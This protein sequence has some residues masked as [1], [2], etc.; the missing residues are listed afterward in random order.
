MT[1]EDALAWGFSGPPLRASG[2]AWD[3]RRSQPYEVYDQL[4]FDIP[5]GRNGDCYDRYLVRMAEMR[6]EHEDHQAVPGADAARAR[7]G[8]QD[9]KFTPPQRSEMKRSMEALI[10]HFKL[11]H[12]GLSHPGRRDLH[13]DRE[14]EGRVRR[15]SDRRRQQPAVSLQ[16]PAD[17]L[18][19]PAGDRA[20]FASATCWPTRWP[21][22]ARSTSCSARSTGRA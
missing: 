12:R 20:S 5:V 22:S 21:S 16:D 19:L 18:R 6:R 15:L 14:P 7:C 10:H 13:G 2:I 8:S 4:E 9:N 1:P 3:L 17:R 11:L